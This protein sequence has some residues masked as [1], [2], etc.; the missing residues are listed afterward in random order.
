MIDNPTTAAAQSADPISTCSRPLRV[1]RPCRHRQA[2]LSQPLVR[3]ST[4]RL[5][6]RCCRNDGVGFRAAPSP[7]TLRRSRRHRRTLFQPALGLRAIAIAANRRVS[8]PRPQAAAADV[9]RGAAG[10]A[11]PAPAASGPR[12]VGGPR[13]SGPR[14]VGGG[15]G[16]RS[17]TEVR[18]DVACRTHSR[19]QIR[20]PTG[21]S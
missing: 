7:A 4:G 15:S 14:R 19:R 12:R 17:D 8:P 20:Y 13:G 5:R 16:P 11:R 18:C 21:H 9:P 6:C 2:G 1:R 3:P 10:D